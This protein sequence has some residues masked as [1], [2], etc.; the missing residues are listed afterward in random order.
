MNMDPTI[1]LGDKI[2]MNLFI[3]QIKFKAFTL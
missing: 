2:Q 3:N 1:P